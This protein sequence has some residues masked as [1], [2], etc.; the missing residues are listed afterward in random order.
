M[1][2]LNENFHFTRDVGE[3]NN[4]HGLECGLEEAQTPN[5][6]SSHSSPFLP[7]L[8]IFRKF[9][10]KQKDNRELFYCEWGFDASIL[11]DFQ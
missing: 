2:I 7:F 8:E 1:Q 11:N 9:I 6:N 3:N 10:Q 5:T 4:I